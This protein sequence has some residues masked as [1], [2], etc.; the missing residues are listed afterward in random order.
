[1]PDPSIILIREWT[2]AIR[3]LVHPFAVVD[4]FNAAVAALG[5]ITINIPEIDAVFKRMTTITGDPTVDLLF[6]NTTNFLTTPVLAPFGS[7]AYA[8]ASFRSGRINEGIYRLGSA[9]IT[10]PT[11]AEVLLKKYIEYVTPEYFTDQFDIDILVAN[12]KYPDLMIIP[13]TGADLDSGLSLSTRRMINSGLRQMQRKFP[14][15][16][17]INGMYSCLSMDT[18]INA[19]DRLVQAMQ[20]VN[21]CYLMHNDNG[22]ISS[23][24]IVNRS[25]SPGSIDCGCTSAQSTYG[26]SSPYAFMEY[27]LYGLTNNDPVAIQLLNDLNSLTA[28]KLTD[29]TSLNAILADYAQALIVYEYQTTVYANTPELWSPCGVIPASTGG[30]VA[31]N[32]YGA[33]YNK[34]TANNLLPTNYHTSAIAGYNM[35]KLLL[36]LSYGTQIDIMRIKPNIP[37]DPDVIEPPPPDPKP[38]SVWWPCLCVLFTVLILGVIVWGIIALVQ[39]SKKKDS[40]NTNAYKYMSA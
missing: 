14:N 8:A 39:S 2:Q 7:F 17:T 13:A 23:C 5:A 30:I 12:K 29:E 6:Y 35:V 32:P 11:S 22:S 36:D 31:C 27:L 3:N 25:C 19:Y 34:N 37:I 18:S 16:S 38:K 28:I 4:D 9:T 1:M 40:S 15:K 10:V 26:S 21:G 33:F 24:K 20:Q